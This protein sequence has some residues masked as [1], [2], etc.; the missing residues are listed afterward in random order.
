LI[1]IYLPVAPVGKKRLLIVDGHGSHATDD[2]MW[3]CYIN[4]VY[5]LYL[6]AHS[7]LVLQPLDLSFFSPLKTAYR[8]ELADLVL[9]RGPVPFNKRD[10]LKAY[11]KAR[12]VA[13]T[14][15]IIRA[16]WVATGLW[17]INVE[18]PLGNSLVLKADQEAR[19]KVSSQQNQHH[20]TEPPPVLHSQPMARA[21]QTPQRSQEVHKLLGSRVGQLQQL[22]RVDPVARVTFSKIARSLDNKAVQVAEYQQKIQALEAE[23]ERLRPKKRKRVQTD[24]NERFAT[25]ADIIK[26]KKA[27]GK[28]TMS[29]V[30]A[31][32]LVFE[33]MCF[34]WA[35]SDPVVDSEVKEVGDLDSDGSGEN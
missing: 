5:L 28:A 7:S 20:T 1:K 22:Y 12:R 35:I 26:A 6:P 33:D 11:S 13:G 16:G 15:R 29:E 24:L 34:E 8:K 4:D 17:P 21:V 27:A 32:S 18:K 25:I 2:F 9:L 19:D 3:H 23:V 10:F 31:N 14:S 30:V